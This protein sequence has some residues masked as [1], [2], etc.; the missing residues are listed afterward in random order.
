MLERISFVVFLLV[1]ITQGASAQ[2]VWQETNPSS[3][4]NVCYVYE[5]GSGISTFGSMVSVMGHVYDSTRVADSIVSYSVSRSDD[6]GRTWTTYDLGLPRVHDQNIHAFSLNDIQQVSSSYCVV[7]GY[8]Y[9]N[10]SPLYLHSFDGGKIWSRRSLP[11]KGSIIAVNFSYS[12]N[13]IVVINESNG[14]NPSIYSVSDSGIHFVKIIKFIGSI[15]FTN[16]A[17]RGGGRFCTFQAGNG[18]IFSNLA[19]SDNIDSTSPI[20]DKDVVPLYWFRNCEFSGDTIIAFGYYSSDGTFNT[21]TTEGVVARSS[22]NGTSWVSQRFSHFYL[23]FSGTIPNRDTIIVAGGSH[24]QR[25]IYLLSTDNGITWRTDTLSV[26]SGS[27]ER[28]EDIKITDN[29]TPIAVVRTKFAG[30]APTII[31]RG[32]PTTSSVKPNRNADASI[33]VY[34]SPATNYVE[35]AFDLNANSDVSLSLLDELG[36]EVTRRQELLGEGWHQLRLET[37][38]VPSGMYHVQL[39]TPSGKTM[40]KVLFMH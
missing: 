18:K 12:A 15:G 30:G 33:S 28:I 35:V 8:D 23:L 7:G 16:I 9:H 14:M 3:K 21:K 17:S 5:S 40:S 37:S 11:D 31:S 13:G 26:D 22:N 6:D 38:T 36:R 1:A 29:G 27:V 25:P 2:F 10:D 34:P 4:D 24:L 19:S 20:V 32:T 39:I